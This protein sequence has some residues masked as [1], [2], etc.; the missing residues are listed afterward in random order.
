MN[1]LKLIHVA[2]CFIVVA[3]IAGAQE[4]LGDWE[5]VEKATALET[6]RHLIL[7]GYTENSSEY[8]ISRTCDHGVVQ[9]ISRAADQG[10]AFDIDLVYYRSS[11]Y[12]SGKAGCDI[13]SGLCN[14]WQYKTKT[15]VDRDPI[16]RHTWMYAFD[17][18]G[19]WEYL[20]SRMAY[21]RKLGAEQNTAGHSRDSLFMG[22][23]LA[24]EI[25]STK[26]VAVFDT[27]RFAEAL[28]A[29]CGGQPLI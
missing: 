6:T 27:S 15:R 2:M 8:I 5:Y 29:W 26:G 16:M 7:R 4:G 19:G 21:H 20:W 18:D 17:S 3:T 10:D 23:R 25:S 22:E 13:V 28:D 1:N 24:I 14:G 9:L 12:R 11:M